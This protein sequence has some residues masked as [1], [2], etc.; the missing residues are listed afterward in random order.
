MNTQHLP[1]Y[2]P[3]QMY[4]IHEDE[5]FAWLE[6]SIEVLSELKIAHRISG[7]SYRSGETVYIGEYVDLPIFMETWLM[8]YDRTPDDYR[9]FRQHCKNV[10]DGQCAYIRSLPRFSNED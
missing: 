2:P 7:S 1:K 4:V 10:G 3:T 5:E 8:H 9:Y 6:V